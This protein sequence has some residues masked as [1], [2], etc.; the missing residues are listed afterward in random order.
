M[1]PDLPTEVVGIRPGE[2]LQEVMCPLDDSHLTVEFEDH[3]VIRPAIRFFDLDMDYTTNAA[4]ETAA[5]V[6]QGVP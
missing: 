6:F 5:H 1:A 4:G 3:Y 2:K